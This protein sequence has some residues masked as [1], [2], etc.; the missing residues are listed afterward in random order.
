MIDNLSI[1]RGI[2]VKRE[3]KIEGMDC[4]HCV[5]SIESALNAMEGVK[6]KVNLKKGIAVV[7]SDAG[8][9]DHQLMSKINGLGYHAVSVSVKKGLW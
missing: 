1:K 6:A 4:M 3:I 5:M 9:T 2:D 8:V 7:K